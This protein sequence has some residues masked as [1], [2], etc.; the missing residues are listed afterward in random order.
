MEETFKNDRQEFREYAVLD[1]D[2]AIDGH[3]QGQYQCFCKSEDQVFSTDLEELKKDFCYNYNRD[4]VI[5]SAFKNIIVIIVISINLFIELVTSFLVKKIGYKSQ[6]FLI[7]ENTRI[8]FL[9]KLVNTG[10]ARLISQSNFKHT[11]F[12]PSQY[13]ESLDFQTASMGRGSF[14]D[15]SKNWYLVIGSE[16]VSI[17]ISQAFLPWIELFIMVAKNFLK[18]YWDCPGLLAKSM[19]DEY[20]KT[21]SKTV[22]D[23]VRHQVGP[24]AKF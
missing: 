19:R 9:V 6:G 7:R 5:Y 21:K 3:G 22:Q 2:A 10:F 4:M 17:M 15:F 8:I 20:P 23:F 1:K 16:I 18:R 12:D 13:S 14:N 11:P 24:E